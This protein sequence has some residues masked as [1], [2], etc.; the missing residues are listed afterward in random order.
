MSIYNRLKAFVS[1]GMEEL[2]EERLAIKRALDELHV[3]AFIYEMD[4]GARP[5]SIRTSYLSEVEASDVYIGLFWKKLGDS[6][7]EEYEHADKLA[8]DCLIYEKRQDIET[9]RDEKLTEFLDNLNDIESGRTIRWFNDAGELSKYVQ[10][11]L[12]GWQT[13]LI[14]KKHARREVVNLTL[15]EKR[16]RNALLVLLQKV[17][18]F[19]ISGVLFDVEDGDGLIELEN[20][21][22]A[23]N[24][25]T[26]WNMVLELPDQSNR[27]IEPSQPL[28]EIF[29]NV[30]RS[31]LILGD[32][33]AGKTTSLLL[34][35]QALIE[36]AEEDPSQPIPVVF[37]LSSW[38]GQSMQEWLIKE[39]KDKYQVPA[40]ISQ[41]WLTNNWVLPML[42]G[43]DEVENSRRQSCVNAIERFLDNSG[44]TGLVVSCRLVEYEALSDK[45]TISGAICLQPLSETQINR[46]IEQADQK[47]E[48]L[49]QALQSDSKLF[50]LAQTPMMLRMINSTYQKEEKLV[51]SAEGTSLDTIKSNIFTHF[52]ERMLKRGKSIVQKYGREKI[53]GNLQTIATRMETSA[54]SILL[55]EQITADWLSAKQRFAYKLIM[56]TLSMFMMLTVIGFISIVLAFIIIGPMLYGWLG[57]PKP[58]VI[59]MAILA[60]W[61]ATLSE[62]RL[63]TITKKSLIV[64]AVCCITQLIILV[65]NAINGTE[66]DTGLWF[67]SL[68]VAPLVFG[69][70]YNVTFRCL[71]IHPF[72][73]LNMVD[74]LAWDWTSFR[75]RLYI[76]G[77]IALSFVTLM[78]LLIYGA[79]NTADRSAGYLISLFFTGGVIITLLVIVASMLHI[80]FGAL[81]P[82]LIK[83][84]TRPNQGIRLSLRNSF[85]AFLIS[86]LTGLF[87]GMIIG[88][89]LAFTPLQPGFSWSHLAVT[90]SIGALI[91]VVIGGF[92]W[93]Q[94]GGSAALK[95]YII[96]LILSMGGVLPL[97][98]SNFLN[99]AC[100][101]AFMKRVGNGY[102]F[103]HRMLQEHFFHQSLNEKDD[104]PTE[105]PLETVRN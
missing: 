15:A 93:L 52:Q 74:T 83:Q 14:R 9:G 24:D 41:Q 20:Q 58:T 16:E 53:L 84:R 66:V 73:T 80:V 44:I 91:G 63:P 11:D 65:A 101:L 64:A 30:G 2:S 94:R 99:V 46:F 67:T 10:Q 85:V 13:R 59:L 37:N 68:V 103:T 92:F 49:H 12:A 29:E 5:D 25:Q 51:N 33:G 34:L 96:R 47:L 82:N 19:W 3:D 17:K 22:W 86:V 79:A 36:K 31:L 69:G 87:A 81:Q 55:M 72:A 61:L 57:E 28:I 8:I 32:P 39:L 102:I 45:L 35:T 4:Q 18:D 104:A 97:R 48:G 76:S 78:W 1:S 38:Q 7:L 88:V 71:G 26:Q 89:A 54:D 100:Q 70:I 98:F 40:K 60:A 77:G 90:S 75:K 27:Q 43:L 42:D 50:E 95:H 62:S 23:G 6:T 56:A 21:S 105:H